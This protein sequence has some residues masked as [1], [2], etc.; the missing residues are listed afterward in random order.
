MVRLASLIKRVEE[1]KQSA[2]LEHGITISTACVWEPFDVARLTTR[3]LPSIDL[4]ASE[5]AN[6]RAAF[7]EMKE[8][9]V[10]ALAAMATT[11]RPAPVERLSQSSPTSSVVRLMPC[12]VSAMTACRRSN[13]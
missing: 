6:G 10:V 8:D 9:E 13:T 5:Y 2:W 11:G 1:A 12:H 3:P 7:V 4:P